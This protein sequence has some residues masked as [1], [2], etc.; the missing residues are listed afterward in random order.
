MKHCRGYARLVRALRIGE[1]SSAAAKL[2]EAEALFQSIDAEKGEECSA[3]IQKCE[4]GTNDKGEQDKAEA[5]LNEGITYFRDQ[6]HELAK[7]KFE[8]TLSVFTE[9]QMR[10]KSKNAKN[11]LLLVNHLLLQP[12]QFISLQGSM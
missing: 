11:G 3:L 8:E 12:H 7:T 4:I 5:L 9:L 2:K 6:Q 10:R 1:Y